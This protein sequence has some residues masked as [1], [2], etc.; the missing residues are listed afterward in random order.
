MDIDNIVLAVS[1]V[2]VIVSLILVF[3]LDE[4]GWWAG[5]AIGCVGLIA[6]SVY[7]FYVWR[8]STVANLISGNI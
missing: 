8:I 5:F 1:L 2:I 7:K 6:I 4:K 3:V